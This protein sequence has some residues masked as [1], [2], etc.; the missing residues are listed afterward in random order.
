MKRRDGEGRR[1]ITVPAESARRVCRH[2]MQPEE[3]S[4]DAC[5]IST[6][7]IEIF[8]VVASERRARS[9]RALVLIYYA[10]PSLSHSNIVCVCMC[11]IGSPAGRSAVRSGR[12][13]NPASPLSLGASAR[14]A[15]NSPLKKNQTRASHSNSLVRVCVY[16]YM[17]HAPPSR[18]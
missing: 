5:S 1:F 4:V 17:T 11:E 12:A 14:R 15:L 18:V 9:R 10:A 7:G 3:K 13:Q 6:R 2:R 8:A 16:I